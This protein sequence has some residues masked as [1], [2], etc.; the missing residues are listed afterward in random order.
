MQLPTH[1]SAAASHCVE[2][3]AEGQGHTRIHAQV[4]FSE[5]WFLV[6]SGVGELGDH[7]AY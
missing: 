3:Q 1:S 7:S 5:A 6:E 4:S 2:T